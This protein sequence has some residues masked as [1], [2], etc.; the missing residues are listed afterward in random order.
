[1][2]KHQAQQALCNG[3]D[4]VPFASSAIGALAPGWSTPALG[5]QAAWPPCLR[6]TLDIMLNSPL[7][8]VLMWGPDQ[9]MLFNEA[10]AGLMGA[11]QWQAPGGKVPAL[12][13]VVWSW[14]GAALDAAWK[15]TPSS[16]RNCE[17]P[18]WRDGA[19]E[20]RTLD[21][22]YTPV[23]DE[24][25]LVRGVLCSLAPSAMPPAADAPAAFPSRALQVLVVEDNL[26]SQYLVCE[27]LRAFGHQ[28]QA[29][30]DGESAAVRLASS[31]FDLLFTDV[32]LP[33]MSGVELARV[34]LRRQPGLKILFATGYDE[35][36]TRSLEFSAVSL[37]KPYELD[38]LKKALDNISLQL[39][40]DGV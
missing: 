11:Q 12:R 33:G 29:A 27:M 6:L 15:G 5:A 20:Y 34:A 2:D 16:L 24:S 9:V 1:M 26:D 8:C 22:Y 10:Y 36:L 32:G 14:N 38:D 35:T 19:Q 30:A 28:V 23:R 18:L 21:L 39:Q 31:H 17:L 40:K 13:P 25:A 4:T 3:P 7:A 37:Q